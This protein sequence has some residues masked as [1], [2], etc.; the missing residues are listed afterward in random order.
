MMSP[1]LTPAFGSGAF[2]NGLSRSTVGGDHHAAVHRIHPDAEE[3]LAA[4]IEIAQRHADDA[5]GQRILVGSRCGEQGAHRQAFR[6]IPL[7]GTEIFRV[8]ILG[9]DLQQGEVIALEAVDHV[10]GGGTAVVEDALHAA[11]A[12][13]ARWLC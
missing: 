5:D 2:G 3:A 9:V 11:L 7:D 8:Q 10:G 6:G 13:A 1:S 4:G 12:Q